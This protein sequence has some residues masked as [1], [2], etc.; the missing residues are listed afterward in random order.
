MGQPWFVH[1][2]AL[3]HTLSHTTALKFTLPFGHAY[4]HTIYTLNHIINRPLNSILLP[5]CSP[6]PLPGLCPKTHRQGNRQHS[7]PIRHPGKVSEH[8]Q[9]HTVIKSVLSSGS[10]FTRKTKS[11]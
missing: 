6:P 11:P 1:A 7:A 5:I 9:S 4:K 3:L 8:T 2:K 10:L